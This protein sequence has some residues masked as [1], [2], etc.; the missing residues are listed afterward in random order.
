MNDL[1]V[2]IALALSTSLKLTL[3]L[4]HK[5]RSRDEEQ[6]LKSSHSFSNYPHLRHSYVSRWVFIG[7]KSDNWLP[8]SF[9]LP[10]VIIWGL[11]L[12]IALSVIGL[13]RRSRENL[14]L[15]LVKILKFKF[16]WD[17]NVWLRFWIW[18]LVEIPQ[19][20]FD[21][22]LCVH[23]V[24]WTEQVTL[25]SRTQPSGPLCLW[26]CF[27]VNAASVNSSE[28]AIWANNLIQ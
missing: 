21:Q 19:I 26:Q 17:A 4:I 10:K 28:G 5:D 12:Y 14:K 22:D 13:I 16:S 24:I 3:I 15:G 23:L 27:S 2:N 6:R 1:H 20:K 9:Q 7:P 8:L 25:V 18:C 11:S